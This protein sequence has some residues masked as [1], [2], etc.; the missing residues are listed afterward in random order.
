MA[1]I[2]GRKGRLYVGLASDTATAE[3]VA[4]LNK[5]SI[6]ASTD[7]IDVT[8]FGDTG[9]VS[10]AGLPD[11]SGSFSGFYDNATVQTYTAATD[12]LARRFYLYPDATVG[13]TGPYWFGTALFDFNAEGDVSGAVT[14]S[15]DWAAASPVAKVG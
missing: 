7:N 4:F 9:K 14:I 11:A 1:R 2:A 15:G 8:A 13:T 12:G 5:W 10:V 6:S 3:A